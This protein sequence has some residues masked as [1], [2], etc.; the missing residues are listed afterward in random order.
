MYKITRAKLK[1]FLTTY[2]SLFTLFRNTHRWNM[3]II[4]FTGQT[5]AAYKLTHKLVQD[6]SEKL[7]INNSLSSLQRICNTEITLSS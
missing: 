2:L 7:Q 1:L 6:P 5:L 4:L 3:R